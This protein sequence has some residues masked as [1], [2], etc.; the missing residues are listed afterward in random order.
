M[1]RGPGEAPAAEGAPP[2]LRLVCVP[3]AG[4][5]AWAFHGWQRAM[6]EGV[7]VLPVELPGR[8]TRVKEPALP[9][10]AAVVSGLVDALAPLLGDR[11]CPVA[12]LGH[13]MG[14]WVAFEVAQ[15][16]RRR[17]MP[18]PVRLY[19]SA[20]RAPHLSAKVHDNDQVCLAELPYHAFWQHFTRRYGANKDLESEGVRRYLFAMLRSDFAVVETYRPSTEQPLEGVPLVAMGAT[21]D[22]RYSREQL[23]A[24]ERASS[25]SFRQEWFP[26][27]HRYIV[28]A[29]AALAPRA[30]VAR[31]LTRLLAPAGAPE[32]H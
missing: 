16:M 11:N 5:G 10:M 12:L 27:P 26:G 1:L 28:D 6:P 22:T 19:A 30:F 24:W 20:N 31:D 29:P 32:P 9:R 17:G 18:P 3:Q 8:N 7:E 25:G 4:M 14:A 13:S 15:E 23:A 21:E 2:R